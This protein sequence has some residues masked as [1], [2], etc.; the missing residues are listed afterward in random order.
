MDF[1]KG[2]VKESDWLLCFKITSQNKI[3]KI[4]WMYINFV[5]AMTRSEKAFDPDY[6]FQAIQVHSLSKYS[7][8]PFEL[9]QRFK[10]AFVNL[11]L[12][13]GIKKIMNQQD[14]NP[15]SKFLSNLVHK[16]G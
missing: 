15:N 1:A 10:K 11:A 13:Y 9:T 3:V 16:Y 12:E 14:L 5:V 6:P 7:A 4:E 2:Q 8:P